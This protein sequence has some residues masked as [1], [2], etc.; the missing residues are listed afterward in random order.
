MNLKQRII[1]YMKDFC[2]EADLPIEELAEDIM[3]EVD[4]VY[5][6]CPWCGFP[7]ITKDGDAE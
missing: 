2:V 3:A 7:V 5:G 4:E 1:E 6:I